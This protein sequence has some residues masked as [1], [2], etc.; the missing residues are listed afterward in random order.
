MSLISE[1]PC[2]PGQGDVGCSSDGMCSC[3]TSA[4]QCR[5]DGKCSSYTCKEGK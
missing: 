2:T 5:D 1:C 3:L 4:D